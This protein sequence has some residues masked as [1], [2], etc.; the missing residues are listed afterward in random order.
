MI[1]N[2]ELPG[3]KEMATIEDLAQRTLAVDAQDNPQGEFE[4]VMPELIM[5]Q[6]F[7]NQS[8]RLV[9]ML[10]QKLRDTQRALLLLNETTE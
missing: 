6:K 4:T 3:A 7:R 2:E 5:A 8:P 10:I 9:L 1:S